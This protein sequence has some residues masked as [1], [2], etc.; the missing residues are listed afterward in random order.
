LGG[1]G[2]LLTLNPGTYI[3]TGTLSLGDFGVAGT[4]VTLYF[5]CTGWP[6]PCAG[7]GEAGAT[8]VG[9]SN[10]DLNISAPAASSGQPYPGMAI[11]SD[12]N[13][14]STLTLQ[15]NGAATI[16]GTVYAKSAQISTTGNGGYTINGTVIVSTALTSAN[17]GLTLNYDPNQNYN[18]PG[19]SGLVR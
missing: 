7:G 5:A 16:T 15:S 13:N 8:V 10:G 2:S 9:S 12:R 6:T 18:P 14:T 4:G 1:G 19:G 3:I 11:F 17:G